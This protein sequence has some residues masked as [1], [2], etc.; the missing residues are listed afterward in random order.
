[1]SDQDKINEF[2]LSHRETIAEAEKRLQNFPYSGMSLIDKIKPGETV[3]DIGCGYNIFKRHI[4]GLVGIDPVFDE[5]DHQVT[6][7][8]FTTDVKFDVAFCLGS[9]QF[10]DET[11]IR[12]QISKIVSLLKLPGRIY[13]RVRL[14]AAESM[15]QYKF[16]WSQDRISSIS[17]D[18]GFH[19]VDQQWESNISDL[20]QRL[21]MEWRR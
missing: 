1:M 17:G 2:Y 13:W 4:P 20:T 14:D 9:V 6:L 12:G 19:V 18:F 21:Y 7:Q 10:G 16:T 11:F 8:D 3:I 15:S 5:A